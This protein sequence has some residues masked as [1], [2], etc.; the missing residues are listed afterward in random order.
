M[1]KGP[2]SSSVKAN[3]DQ[4][5]NVAD[6]YD[7]FRPEP[8]GE[9]VDLLTQLA[10]VEKP[11]VVIDLGCGTGLATRVWENSAAQVI[12]IEPNDD[13]RILAE[14]QTASSHISFRPGYGH[15]TG[16]PDNCADIV[17][18]A[19]SLHWM[20]PESTVSEIDR[21]LRRGGVFAQVDFKWPMTIDWEI[22]LAIHRAKQRCTAII[23]ELNLRK[24]RRYSTSKHFELLRSRTTFR[25]TDELAL[26][27]IQ[28]G[29]APQIIG[30]LKT[31]Q[32]FRQALDYGMSEDELGLSEVS[33]VAERVMG[34]GSRPWFL[35]FRVRV[36]VK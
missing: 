11:S 2:E 30:L 22:T 14:A 35:Y 34:D 10:R 6:E 25:F 5:S 36:A 16:L 20:E 17:T 4:W 12:G 21:I 9:L 7:R 23:D 18:A 24:E 1:K 29:S 3:V 32:D 28:S 13:M 27:R 31:H 19:H 8:P 33:Q 15:D 26:T